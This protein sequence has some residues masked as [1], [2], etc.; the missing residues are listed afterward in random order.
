MGLP[1]VEE[2]PQ[3]ERSPLGATTVTLCDLTT[4]RC[5]AA[6]PGAWHPSSLVNKRCMSNV[7]DQARYLGFKHKLLID[8]TLNMANDATATRFD[9][10][11]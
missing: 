3:T 11:A 8:H 7:D 5:K 4:A 1:K 9:S 2:W 10:L 6:K